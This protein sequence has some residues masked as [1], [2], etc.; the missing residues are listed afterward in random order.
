MCDPFLMLCSNSFVVS[1]ALKAIKLLSE[2]EMEDHA[3]SGL[4]RDGRGN[5][6]DRSIYDRPKGKRLWVGRLYALPRAIG[7]GARSLRKK[8]ENHLSLRYNTLLNKFRALR[9]R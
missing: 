4:E 2:N 1:L 9:Y 6:A 3:E 8:R 7:L 5:D